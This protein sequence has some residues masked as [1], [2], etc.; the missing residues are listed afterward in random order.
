MV[1]KKQ[2]DQRFYGRRH[3][4]PLNQGRQKALEQMS[5]QYGVTVSEDQSPQ[6]I[7]PKDFF[8]DLT[9]EIWLEIGFG[10]GEHLVA[11]AVANSKIGMIGC[12]PFINGVSALYKSV[13]EQKIDNIRVWAD[14]MR[15]FLDKLQS[16][17]ISRV[18]VLFPDPW[19]K[20][21]HHKRRIINQEN[22]NR[23]ARV[24]KIGGVL[25]LASDHAGMA[26]WM[27]NECLVHKQLEWT[28]TSKDDW[29]K[30]PGDWLVRTRYQEKAKAGKVNW[31]IECQKI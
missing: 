15:P 19:P 26:E 29:Q 23:I 13:E 14:D 22:L 9:P 12:E 6:S 2:P 1:Y 20:T 30:E 28:A 16:D 27:L 31:F 11:Q 7:D 17:S 3:G 25:R 10:N 24:L 5:Y 8:E 4:R 18:F 21:R